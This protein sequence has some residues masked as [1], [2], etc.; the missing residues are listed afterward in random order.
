MTRMSVS[1]TTAKPGR[2]PAEQCRREREGAG[3][4]NGTGWA[5]KNGDPRMPDPH[6]TGKGKP[7]WECYGCDTEIKY[8]GVPA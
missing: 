6:H 2:E 4:M 7:E 8:V 3:Q 1:P 5:H